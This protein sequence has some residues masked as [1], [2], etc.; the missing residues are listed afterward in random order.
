METPEEYGRGAKVNRPQLMRFQV[1]VPP[2]FV[3]SVVRDLEAR[4]GKVARRTDLTRITG[5]VPL[6]AMAEYSVAL[7][8]LTNG[9]GTYELVAEH[10]EKHPD[11]A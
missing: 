10:S 9:Y 1:L 8:E 11:P 5:S 4:G 6:E 3:E 2:T 7:R